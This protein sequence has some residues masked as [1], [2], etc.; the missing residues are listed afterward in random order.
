MITAMKKKIFAVLCILA[1]LFLCIRLSF[2]DKPSEAF[3]LGKIPEAKAQTVSGRGEQSE[4]LLLEQILLAP[5]LPEQPQPK[6]SD[7]MHFERLTFPTPVVELNGEEGNLCYRWGRGNGSILINETTV[8][9][10]IDCYFPEQTRQQKLFFVAE[11]PD[12][13]PQEVFRQ[14]SR[15][16]DAGI[17]GSPDL[18]E[19]RVVWPLPVEGGYLYELDGS[20]YILSAD[21]R[22]T[23][24]LCDLRELMGALY[25]FSPWITDYDNKCDALAD[26]SRLLACTDEGLYEYDL[27]LGEKTLLEPAVFLPYEIVHIEGDCDCGETGFEFTGPIAAEYTPDGQ[28]Y[29]FVTGDEY[30]GEESITLK[31]ADGKTLYHK[32]FDNLHG[33]F[34]WMETDDTVCMAFFYKSYQ[35]EDAWMDLTDV[36]T[37]ETTTFA[38]PS[39]VFCGGAYGNFWDADT[40]VYCKEYVPPYRESDKKK[41][42]Y[43]LYR[44]RNE[45]HSEQAPA[46]NTAAGRNR[47]IPLGSDY[48]IVSE[49]E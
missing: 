28:G 23:T 27:T 9:L 6:Q 36:S 44:F 35:E 13:V 1:V 29:V 16:Y 37:G 46:A 48:I 47:M 18:F 40:L 32:E 2:F 34:M 38:I 11:A 30:G 31:S 17:A 26:A 22:E 7:E 20:L 5:T 43:A 33:D 4:H 10:S 21:F 45:P 12:F 3:H 41:C 49:G 39:E 14:N 24:F 19:H 42:E 8:L 15:E 25:T